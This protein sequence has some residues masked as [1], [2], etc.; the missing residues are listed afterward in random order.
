[1]LNNIRYTNNTVIFTNG[2]IILQQIMNRIVKLNECFEL[3]FNI[4]KTKYLVIKKK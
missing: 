2:M 1:M 4:K 3:S